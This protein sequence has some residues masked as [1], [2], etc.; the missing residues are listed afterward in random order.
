M[1]HILVVDDVALNLKRAEAVLNGKYYVSLAHSGKEAVEMLKN[2]V[3]DLILLDVIMPEMDG[4][5]TFGKIRELPGLQNVPIIFL[6]AD[7]GVGSEI[8]GLQMGAMDYI[9]KPFDP[10]VMLSR[11]KRVLENEEMKRRL[12]LNAK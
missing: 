1:K 2:E 4:Y 6:T 9:H 5:E 8:M 10:S 7:T 12:E 3:P 11:V